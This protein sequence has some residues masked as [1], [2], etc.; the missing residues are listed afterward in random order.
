MLSK[1]QVLSAIRPLRLVF[2]GGLLCVIDAPPLAFGGPVPLR[3]DVLNDAAGM[4]LVAVG[5]FRLAR[6]RV[7]PPW[8]DHYGATMRWVRAVAMVGVAEAIVAQIVFSRPPL[9]EICLAGFRIVQVGTMVLLCLS[10]RWLCAEAGLPSARRSWDFTTGFFVCVWLIPLGLAF[11]FDFLALMSG[12]SSARDLGAAAYVI[13]AILAAPFVSLYVST[14]RIAGEVR[15]RNDRG[16]SRAGPP[17]A[18]P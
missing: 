9:L 6:I 4:I 15:T 8:N 7:H 5:V 13:Q 18:A 16:L 2:W 17:Q 10:M 11:Y 14:S 3:L 1:D 12:K